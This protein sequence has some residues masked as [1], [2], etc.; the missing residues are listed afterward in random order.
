ME[1]E[2]Q[3]VF[4]SRQDTFKQKVAAAFIAKSEECIKL[5]EE[6]E[7]MQAGQEELEH[8]RKRH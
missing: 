8:M 5:R 7:R 4:V 2:I 6:I 1:E 3:E